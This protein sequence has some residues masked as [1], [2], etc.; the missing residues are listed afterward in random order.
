M[1]ATASGA[2]RIL[3]YVEEAKSPQRILVR[4]LLKS[5][6][7]L[8]AKY[9]ELRAE[10]KRWR[11]QAAAVTKS[12]DAWRRRALAGEAALHDPRRP[13]RPRGPGAG[14]IGRIAGRPGGGRKR[15]RRADPTPRAPR[16][17]PGRRPAGRRVAP[18]PRGARVTDPGDGAPSDRAG[19]AGPRTPSDR[20]GRAAPVGGHRPTWCIALAVRLV[21][22]VK[23]SI[24]SVPRALAAVLDSLTGRPTAAP[25]SATTVRCWLMRLGLWALLRPLPR[26]DDWAYLIDHTVQIGR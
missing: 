1:E 7:S 10:C 21:T 17:R 24:R 18:R 19:P 23:L 25:M 5:R 11:N 2:K 22:A 16:R 14:A 4:S 20:P 6:N 3:E 12:R 8:R 26:A 9:R 15:G 13:C